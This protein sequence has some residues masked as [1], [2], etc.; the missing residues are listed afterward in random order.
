MEGNSSA[1]SQFNLNSTP[2][3]HELASSG[4]FSDCQN[5]TVTGETFNNVTNHYTT[6][7]TM[8]SDF[9][10]IPL[11]GIDLRYEIRVDIDTGFVNRRERERACVR[12][13]YS[14][15]IEGRMSNV[16]VAM[17][18]GPDAKEEWHQHIAQCIHPNMVQIYGAASS[19]AGIHATILNDVYIYAYCSTDLR[20]A[21][22]Y[23]Y[24]ALQ[25]ELHWDQCTDWIRCSTGRICAELAPKRL[26]YSS[27]DLDSI[28]GMQGIF[29]LSAPNTET[30]VIDTMMLET[31]HD[32]C[33]KSL[34]RFR[35]LT[36]SLSGTANIPAVLRYSPSGLLEDS[37][38]IAAL[39]NV[40]AH[41]AGW[42]AYAAGEVMENGW[43]R[44]RSCEAANGSFRLVK[45]SNLEFWLS[46]ANHIFTR[47]QITSNFKDYVLVDQV[48]FEVKLPFT[49]KPCL[50]PGFLF[51]CPTA[52]F[53][54]APSSFRWP[55]CPA[56]WSL[57]PEGA[58]LLT[59][60]EAARL[61]FPGH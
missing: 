27:D 19:G 12:R 52:D 55:E 14:A 61:G 42:N 10:M 11:G 15:K 51:L 39:P 59:A 60:E 35:K 58:D 9:R 24:S 49:T 50:P 6:V 26:F 16:T 47:L 45:W 41:H 30:M 22:D 8:P 37:V 4:M 2:Y 18:Q 23:V 44:F 17:Y 21:S 46:Q 3:D 48:N 13:V 43:T 34:R 20:A 57:D 54:L 53:N 40:A 1:E 7:S 25:Q 28:L 5:F 56:Y 38:E 32:I 36:M 29:S 31:Y 33:S